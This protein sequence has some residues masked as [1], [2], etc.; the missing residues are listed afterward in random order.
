MYAGGAVVSISHLVPKALSWG[1]LFLFGT[2]SMSNHE[3]VW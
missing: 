1:S 2:K 3:L